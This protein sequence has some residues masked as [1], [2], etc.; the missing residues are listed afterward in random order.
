MQIERAE[1]R[2]DARIAI[3]GAGIAGLASAYLL[4]RRYRVTLFEAAPHLGGHTHTVDVELEG[5]S[6]P[7]DTGFLVFNDRTY[8]NL[9]ALFDEIGVKAHRTDMSFSVSLD[10]GQLEWAGTNLNTV[11]AQRRNLFSPNFLGMLR[12]I[13]RFNASAHEHLQ[14]AARNRWSVGELLLD[15]GYGVPFQRHYLLPMASAI[16]SSAANDILRFPAVSFL[17]FCLNHALLQVNGRP[18]W[19]TVAGGGREYVRRIAATLDDVRVDTPVRAVT[20]DA[21]G[22]TVMTDSAGAERF[23]AVVLASHAPTSLRLLSDADDME[24]RVLGAVRYQRNVAMLH[25]DTR[26]LPR[27]RRVWS[28]WNYLS[29]HSQHRS[30]DAQPA[31]VSYLLNQLQPLPFRTPVIV[32]LNPT[33]A[34]APEHEIGCYE[35][36]HP[37]LD[38]ACVDAQQRLPDIQGR[39]STWYAGAWTGYGFHEDGLKSA[40]RIAHSFDVAPSWASL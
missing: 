31:C 26:L 13:L 6:H 32:T 3:V 30:S 19:R 5:S 1:M 29:T 39:R 11:F 22:V 25:T 18:A 9:I 33:E 10:G 4:A 40:L 17:R 34:P 14:S 23:D 28:A 2:Q 16:W 7:V 27:R 20:R 24:R 38:L 12:D 21:G 15:G 37:L 8:P 35:Y 36:E